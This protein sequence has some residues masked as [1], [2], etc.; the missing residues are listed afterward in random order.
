M[1]LFKCLL[2]ILV[3]FIALHGRLSSETCKSFRFAFMLRHKRTAKE[4]V[5]A[6]YTFCRTYR[7]F[8]TYILLYP[9]EF[10]SVDFCSNFAYP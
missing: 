3:L 6:L 5:Q 4:F 10:R 2:E 8:K 1:V 9:G 7:P